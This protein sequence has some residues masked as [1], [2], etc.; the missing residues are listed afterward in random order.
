M[1]SIG[2]YVSH[3]DLGTF[4]VLWSGPAEADRAATVTTIRRQPIF[5]LLGLPRLF[6]R[7]TTTRVSDNAAAIGEHLADGAAS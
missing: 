5:G 2:R 7:P 3:L 6:V 4:A 1:G